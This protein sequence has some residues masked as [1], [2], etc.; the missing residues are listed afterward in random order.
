MK[1]RSDSRLFKLS[2]EQQDQLYDWVHKLG[3]VKAKE[4]VALPPPDGFGV[5]THLNSLCRFVA[6]Y[7]EM[8]KER[9]FFDILRCASGEL[10]PETL[11]AAETMT[12]Q[13][14]FEIATSPQ[15]ELENFRLLSRWIIH[16]KE[17][18]LKERTLGC[19]NASLKIC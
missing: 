5:K 6:R 7:S 11:R 18:E 1:P 8:R 3:Y 4:L 16:L 17:H 12:H 10:H 2:A 14:A 15:R 13:M 9:E 19:S